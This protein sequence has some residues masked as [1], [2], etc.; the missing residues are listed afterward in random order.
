MTRSSIHY[1]WAVLLVVIATGLARVVYP[2]LAASNIIMIYLLAVVLVAALLGRGPSLFA[3]FLSVA[4][5]DFLYVPPVGSFAVDDIE[6]LVTFGVMIVV[7]LLTSGLVFRIRV[8]AETARL[9]EFHARTLYEM[10]RRF[11]L[12]A[13]AEEILRIAEDRIGELFAGD[14]WVFLAEGVSGLSA[15]PGITSRFPLD[16]REMKVALWTHHHGVA[17]GRGTPNF[18]EARAL[19]A[20]LVATRGRLGVLGIHQ[21]DPENPP[22]GERMALVQAIAGQ[23]ALVLE[24]AAM[25]VETGKAKLQVE[26]DRLRDT[27]LSSISHDLRTPLATIAGA[28]SGLLE[29]DGALDPASRKAM[30]QSICTE[31]DRLNR[32]VGNLLNMTRLESGALELRRE[33]HPPDEVIGS[34]LAS[35][36][37]RLDDRPVEVRAAAD[38]P[39]VRMDAILIEQ[40]LL[41]LVEN[42]LRH[43]GP[44][45]PVEI[46]MAE[47]DGELVVSVADRGPGIPEG[48][49]EEIFGKFYRSPQRA[50]GVGLGL[51]ICRGIVEAHGGTIQAVNRDGGG[52]V[53]TFRLPAG[54]EA[55]MIE[56]EDP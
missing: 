31:A 23:L 52:A 33:W 10:S 45:S 51:A 7:A 16:H 27:L 21:S 44:G 47:A 53:F 39:L 37:K 12:A 22:A 15:G 2:F 18:P 46:G 1:L 17:A 24:R 29:S 38:L 42:V 20:P 13:D 19:Y 54:G 41:N 35:F 25:A 40:V 28:G 34:A 9:R 8:Q 48:E 32:L 6:Y 50:D 14:V 5:F 26:T 11:S 3:A 36:G 30:I 4:L 55:P 49:L 56:A 43:A